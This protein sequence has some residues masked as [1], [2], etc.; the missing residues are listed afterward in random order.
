MGD[1]RWATDRWATAILSWTRCLTLQTDLACAQLY[2]PMLWQR[3]F[4]GV[5]LLT[6]TVNAP[7]P[8]HPGADLPEDGPSTENIAVA[9]IAAQRYSQWSTETD[10][11]FFSYALDSIVG[12]L[13][14][15]TEDPGYAASF[16]NR[17]LLAYFE[18]ARELGYLAAV[19]HEAR[20][21]LQD[22]PTAKWISHHA[23]LV[24][25]YRVWSSGWRPG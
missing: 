15:H 19:A 21:P 16:W 2:A 25:R 18:D 1:A 4:A 3:L 6:K 22:A 14:E 10:A 23:E 17:R 7:T 12:H 11:E 24:R 9:V 13:D 5:D 20:I 8:A